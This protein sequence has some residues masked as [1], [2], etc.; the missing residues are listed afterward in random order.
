[1]NL[2]YYLGIS[3]AIQ[4][5]LFIFAFAYRTD[6][7]T[8]IAYGFT[9]I[10]ISVLAFFSEPYS[11]VKLVLL[12][13]ISLWGLRLGLFLFIR[14]LKQKKDRRFDE[15]RKNF[16]NFFFFWTFQGVSIWLILL[17][18]LYFF[19]EPSNFSLLVLPGFVVWLAGFLIESIADFQKFRFRHNPKNKDKWIEHGL[20]NYSRHPNYFGE[21]LCWIGVYIFVFSFLNITQRIIG[22]ISPV[23]IT[24][25]LLF[26]SGIPKLEDY[27]DK[28]WGENKE[29][30]RYKNK[31]SILLPWFKK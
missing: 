13:M 9:F 8:D 10:L 3:V 25:L 24:F 19:H 31:T 5:T 20:W 23:Y 26:V 18:S 27:A 16:F 15:I 2:L 17:P 30:I 22:L 12:T 11:L 4:L 1:M 21:I 7:L 14:I 28:K 29:Y 6:K